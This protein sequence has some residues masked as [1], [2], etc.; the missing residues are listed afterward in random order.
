MISQFAET[1]IELRT[2]KSPLQVL[3]FQIRIPFQSFH[4]LSTEHPYFLP[5][6]RY[7]TVATLVIISSGHEQKFKTTKTLT[8]GCDDLTE[9]STGKLHTHGGR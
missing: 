9:L 1:W 6:H 2:F 7:S 4:T 8:L 5:P 3:N